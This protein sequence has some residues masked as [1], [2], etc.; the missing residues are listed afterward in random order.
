MLRDRSV[1]TM[2]L[3]MAAML[4]ACASS[5]GNDSALRQQDPYTLVAKKSLVSSRPAMNRDGTINVVIEI[6][7]GTNAKWEVRMSDG[8][9]IWEFTGKKPRVVPYLAYP[10]NYGMIPRT[11]LDEESGGDGSA[12]DVLLLGPAVDRG[13][14]VRASA[15][16]VIRLL[17]RAEQDDKIL[18]V[19]EGTT[20][21]RATD[22]TLLERYFPG[23]TDILR[24][25]FDNYAGESIS[26]L[27]LGPR[28]SAQRLIEITSGEYERRH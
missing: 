15:I 14:V 1:P 12:L 16:G 2:S 6:P 7:A 28:A 25:W 5:G 17:D 19:M 24:I 27:G 3:L 26:Y 13:S 21:E 18:A 20:F 9:L 4:L 11:L 22:L 10:A 8:A 23:V